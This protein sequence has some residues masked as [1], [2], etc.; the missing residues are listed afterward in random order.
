MKLLT[1]GNHSH[2]LDI[3]D[4]AVPVV[5]NGNHLHC[6]LVYERK[7]FAYREWLIANERP[8]DAGV[9]VYLMCISEE[10]VLALQCYDI[11]MVVAGVSRKG[12][13]VSKRKTGTKRILK[14][15]QVNIN[16]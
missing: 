7:I 15:H 12:C 5:T 16:S 1:N 6:P 4:F 3:S 13:N 10:P 9:M 2:C 8:M 14:H 11:V